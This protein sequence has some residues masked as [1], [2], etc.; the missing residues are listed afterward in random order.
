MAKQLGSCRLA[1]RYVKL[2]VGTLNTRGLSLAPGDSGLMNIRCGMG[3]GVPPGTPKG[4]LRFSNTEE[5]HF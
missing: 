3:W 1:S 5:V 4:I 2:T